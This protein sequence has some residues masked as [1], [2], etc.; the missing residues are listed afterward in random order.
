MRSLPP[1]ATID[2]SCPG[3]YRSMLLMKTD[4]KPSIIKFQITPIDIAEIGDLNSRPKIM[5][6]IPKPIVASKTF[7]KV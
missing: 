5:P 1:L 4:S 7:T 3:K 6:N 2:N